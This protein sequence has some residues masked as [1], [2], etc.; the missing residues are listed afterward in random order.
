[1]PMDRGAHRVPVVLDDEDARDVV[2]RCVVERFVERA[3]VDRAVSEVR[4]RDF[5]L[6]LTHDFELVFFSK[7]EPRAQWCLSADDAVAAKEPVRLVEHVHRPTLT[8]G[9]A[10]DL[11]EHLRHARVW[12]HATRQR[13]PVISIR[14]DDRII[15]VHSSNRPHGTRFLT[16]VDMTEP[17]NLRLLVRLHRPVFELADQ[18]HLTEPFKLHLRGD[19]E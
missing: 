7:R 8:L 13:V 4:E 17:T 12:C 1:M 6:A 18:L 14:R 5:L 3:L 15:V 11:A 9:A 10:M 2:D 16:C 19:L